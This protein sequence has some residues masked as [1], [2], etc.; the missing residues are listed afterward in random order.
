VHPL[1]AAQADD[2]V[3]GADDL[4][5]AA[6]EVPA[7]GQAEPARQLAGDRDHQRPHPVGELWRMS[8]PGCVL[9]REALLHPAP[10]PLADPRRALAQA[11]CRL[12]A[13]QVGL[14][15]QQQ[16]EPG[17]LHLGVR[18]GLGTGPGPGLGDLSLG[19]ARLVGRRRATVPGVTGTG[20]GLYRRQRR[21]SVGRIGSKSTL[22][23]D[24]PFSRLQPVAAWLP[25]G[26]G[27]GRSP[28]RPR[29]MPG[30]RSPQARR[31]VTPSA[32]KGTA[33]SSRTKSSN[34]RPAYLSLPL[35]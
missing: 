20:R 21:A 14:R 35:A 25:P 6:G 9:E 2:H 13:A 5:D 10:P 18:E 11:A 19:E 30:Y 3:L 23:T 8:G 32:S 28:S 16:D 29:P 24:A 12:W 33:V 15:V 26:G 31:A 27:R 4:P 17:P 1:H 22:P 7:Q 34:S